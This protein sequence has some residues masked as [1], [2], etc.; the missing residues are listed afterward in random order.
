LCGQQWRGGRGTVDV[1]GRVGYDKGS[2]T[3]MI[4]TADP[5]NKDDRLLY[6]DGMADPTPSSN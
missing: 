1:G 5:T 3:C 2:A 6:I 4:A